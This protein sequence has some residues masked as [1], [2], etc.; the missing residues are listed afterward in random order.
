V[1]QPCA[2]PVDLMKS[3]DEIMSFVDEQI[4]KLQ[5]VKLRTDG[6]R[7]RTAKF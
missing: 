4:A 6:E 1:P 2:E 3:D 7:E 5:G